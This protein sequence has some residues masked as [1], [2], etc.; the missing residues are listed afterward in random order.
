MS[1]TKEVKAPVPPV[2]PPVPAVPEKR[3]AAVGE[4]VRTTKEP[5]KLPNGLVIVTH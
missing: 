2:T 4:A 3:D 1:K 5:V